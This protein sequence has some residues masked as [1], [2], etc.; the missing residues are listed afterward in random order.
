MATQRGAATKKGYEFI[1]MFN[2][3][4]FKC[5]NDKGAQWI[6]DNA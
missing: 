6:I 4:T 5:R 1:Q 3:Q 2:V